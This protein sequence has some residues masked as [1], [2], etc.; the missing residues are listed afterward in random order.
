MTNTADRPIA[1]ATDLAPLLLRVVLGVLVLLHG[2][3]KVMAGP[4]YMMALV[5]KA[6]LPSFVAYGVYIG[7][8][9][10]PLLLIAGLCT[11]S[12]AA[13]VAINML[14]AFA[15]VHTGDLFNLS[16]TGGWALELQGLYFFTALAVALLGAGRY[17]L[18]A[19]IGHRLPRPLALAAA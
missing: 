3:A 4:G 16:K 14:F 11:R 8:V 15:L 2:V 9:V 17:S 1:A 6:G 5:S 7:E 10:A 12:A 19:V 18:D 13:V